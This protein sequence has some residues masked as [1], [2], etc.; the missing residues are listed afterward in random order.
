MSTFG[1]YWMWSR[2]TWFQDLI[3]RHNPSPKL[4]LDLTFWCNNA[5]QECINNSHWI[6]SSSWLAEFGIEEEVLSAFHC[7]H[8]VAVIISFFFI[9]SRPFSMPQDSTASNFSKTSWENSHD[10]FLFLFHLAGWLRDTAVYV[11]LNTCAEAP[12]MCFCQII[13][14]SL[15]SRRRR[16]RDAC[17]FVLAFILRTQFHF[18]NFLCWNSLRLGGRLFS[19]CVNRIVPK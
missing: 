12:R 13:F 14:T 1:T 10:F 7:F 16:W 8:S 15:V 18:P 19:F 11:A 17:R 6:S 5:W 4:W 9:A 3:S 2:E